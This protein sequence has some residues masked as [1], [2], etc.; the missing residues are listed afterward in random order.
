MAT[1][2]L[3][4]AEQLGKV[5]TEC[6]DSLRKLSHPHDQQT[7]QWLATHATRAAVKAA[8]AVIVAADNHIGKWGDLPHILQWHR[9]PN[10]EPAHIRT[11]SADGQVWEAEV[12]EIKIGSGFNADGTLPDDTALVF[13]VQFLCPFL[14]SYTKVLS[15]KAGAFDFLDRSGDDQAAAAERMRA[16]AADWAD[17]CAVAGEII[18]TEKQTPTNAR[19]AKGLTI[20]SE[21]R[22]KPIGK[23]KAAS[24]LGQNSGS[25]GVQWLNACIE[26]G[27]INCEPHT[28][29]KN[30]FDIRQFP[31]NVHD[32]L[33]PKPR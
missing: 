27:T 12:T 4:G 11:E 18:R 33:R 21:Y 20:P 25:S 32:Q 9:D 29:Q 26:D 8:R 3:I 30:V 6:E 5:L 2:V 1:D 28:R 7:P 14:R 17:C 31:A 24:L 22:T 10:R 15:S 13:W 23:G 19:N 16:Q